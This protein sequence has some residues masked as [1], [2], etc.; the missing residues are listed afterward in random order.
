[1]AE[2]ALVLLFMLGG[3][4]SGALLSGLFGAAVRLLGGLRRGRGPGSG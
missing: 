2:A 3:L 1:V 4:A